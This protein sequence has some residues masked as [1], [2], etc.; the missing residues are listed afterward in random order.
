[1]RK[2][3]QRQ[4]LEL[5]QTIKQALSNG[6]YAD[7][8]EGALAVGGF[9]E[10]IEG[11]GTQTVALLEEYCDLLY[12]A[13]IGEIGDKQ[14]GRHFDL[15]GNSVRNE[16]KPDRIEIA[17][18]AYNA[19]MSDCIESIYLAAKADPNCDAYWI[20]IPYFERN[21]DGSPG[22]IHFEGV[23]CYGENI[24]CVDWQKYDIEARRPD[25]IF[26]FN[27][28][29]AGNYVT[30]VHPDYYCERLRGLTD[31]LVYCP[32]FVS[33]DDVSEHFC[34]VAGCV[35]AHKVIVQSEKIRNAYIRVFKETYGNRF[36]KPE[37]KFIALGSPKFDK[38]INTRREDCKL[39]DEWHGL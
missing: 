4:I 17:F 21:S 30:T 13:S 39:P 34:T 22:T 14:L 24:E 6:L 8:Q 31:L 20:P 7:C 23:D 29:D 11:E 33:F 15:I 9:I 25:A 16:L 36:G 27:P 12:K 38:V 37:E 10:D 3:H 26:T 2:H 32:Y 28:Y 19:S 18:L 35:Y 1:M 5:L